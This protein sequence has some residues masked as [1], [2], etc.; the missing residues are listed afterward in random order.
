VTAK[1]DSI[2]TVKCAVTMPSRFVITSCYYHILL[3]ERIN[4]RIP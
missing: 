1:C 2:V 3:L 4:Q